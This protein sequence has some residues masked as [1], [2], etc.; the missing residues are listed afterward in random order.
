MNS[1]GK[2]DSNITNESDMDDL[3]I[4]DSFYS[5]AEEIKILHLNQ[6]RLNNQIS[7]SEVSKTMSKDTNPS[8]VDKNEQNLS[9][10]DSST[11]VK[12]PPSS[13]LSK[14]CLPSETET[15][16]NNEDKEI[17]HSNENEVNASSIQATGNESINLESE[18][19]PSKHSISDPDEISTDYDFIENTAMVNEKKNNSKPRPSNI[20]YSIIPNLHKNIKSRIKVNMHTISEDDKFNAQRA[21]NIAFED[22]I[23]EEE[24]LQSPLK[25]RI[26]ERISSAQEFNSPENFS[27]SEALNLVNEAKDQQNSVYENQPLRRFVLNQNYGIINI[28]DVNDFSDFH[29][30]DLFDKLLKRSEK[31]IYNL[32]WIKVRNNVLSVFR[33]QKEPKKCDFV[34]NNKVFV[35][36]E[37]SKYYYDLKYSINLTESN[38]F[39]NSGNE[40]S[41]RFFWCCSPT[42]DTSNLVNITNS[43][44]QSSY[45]TSHRYILEIVDESQRKSKVSISNLDL[46]FQYKGKMYPLRLLTIDSFLKWILVFQL[47]RK[48]KICTLYQ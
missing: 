29:K 44:I 39:L 10:K 3:T 24:F 46:I 33:G 38:L 40:K 45:N 21:E 23:S 2:E 1:K 5:D 12:T 13:T 27:L 42:I 37:D 15:K 9:E 19:K 6:K 41:F 8:S 18:K 31:G 4:I 48:D 25:S 7:D 36:P 22:R 28:N 16:E 47:R 43:Q 35:D 30:R 11:G 26:N 20:K 32:A 34:S 17:E 14:L